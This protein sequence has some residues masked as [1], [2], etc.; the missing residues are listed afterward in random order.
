MLLFFTGI[1][2]FVDILV[3][4]SDQIGPLVSL[5]TLE[6]K[7]SERDAY[8]RET[9]R[10]GA[11][12]LKLRFIVMHKIAQAYADVSSKHIM[13]GLSIVDGMSTV[14]LSLSEGDVDRRSERLRLYSTEAVESIR[15]VVEQV[16]RVLQ[17]TGH[18]RYSWDRY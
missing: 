5:E 1:H 11:L 2:D 13:P 16:G 14:E 12:D 18:W 8:L 9:V 15:R 3:T 6:T 7:R 17:A 4:N 10:K